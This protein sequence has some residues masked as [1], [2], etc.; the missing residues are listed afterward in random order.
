MNDL[1]LNLFFFFLV[2][3]CL[4]LGNTKLD[5]GGKSSRNDIFRLLS[6]FSVAILTRSQAD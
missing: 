5:V 1:V 3:E 2:G 6:F 4:F